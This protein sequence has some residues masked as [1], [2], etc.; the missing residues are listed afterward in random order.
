[1]EDTIAKQYEAMRKAEAEFRQGCVP[2][3][4]VPL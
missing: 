2:V 4:S 1:M 3:P